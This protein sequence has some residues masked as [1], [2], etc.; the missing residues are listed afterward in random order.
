MPF[1]ALQSTSTRPSDAD[2]LTLVLAAAYVVSMLVLAYLLIRSR[3]TNDEPPDQP[4]IPE[5]ADPPLAEQD[6]RRLERPRFDRAPASDLPVWLRGVS[7][8]GSPGSLADAATVI[9]ALLR[10]RCNEDM[11]GGLAL[12]TPRFQEQQRIRLGLDPAADD[13]SR[14]TFADTP[15]VLRSVELL[16]ARGGNLRVRATYDD[17]SV[18]RYV[19]VFDGT[20][21]LID[22][23][24]PGA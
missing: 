5:P 17:R 23:I 7:V 2:P 22:E 16:D 14:V 3:T 1:V 11:S 19:L 15:P 6:A 4:S 9:E 8:A 24:Q 20:T 13:M 10:F 12:C 18:E 21:W